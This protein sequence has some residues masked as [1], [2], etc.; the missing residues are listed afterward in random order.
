MVLI[1]Q[2]KIIGDIIPDVSI[3]RITLESKGQ[4]RIEQNPHIEHDR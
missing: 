1:S 3:G 2:D 4:D